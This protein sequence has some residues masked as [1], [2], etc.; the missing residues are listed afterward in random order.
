MNE[1][2]YFIAENAETENLQLSDGVKIF[3]ARVK[4]SSLGQDSLIRDFSQVEGCVIGKRVDLQRMA[5][6]FNTEIGDF[7]YTGRNFTC[8]NA[9]IGKFCSISW[10]VGVGGANHDY[11][12]ISQH[13]FLYASQFG[14]IEKGQKPGYNRFETECIIGNDVWIGCNAV[15]CRDV[16]IGDG[17]VI[18]AGAVVTKDV[19]PYTIVGGVPAKVIKRRCSEEL[20]SRLQKTQW[21]NLPVE[22][23]KKNFEFF[24][25]NIT[26]T[27]VTEMENL[28]RL[29]SCTD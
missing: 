28:I 23:L 17:A 13:A 29:L 4:N 19:A 22:I 15:V 5:M 1:C 8:W 9:K 10:N 25:S 12:R 27:S 2:N 24:N 6:I 11:N 3:S 26:E 16:K 20:A 21:W 18:A 7:T 14:M